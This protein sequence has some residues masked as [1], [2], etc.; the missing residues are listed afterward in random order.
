MRFLITG[1]AP[2]G[3][4]GVNPSYE[5]ARL[6]PDTLGPHEIFRTCLP[7][8]YG[9]CTAALIEKIEQYRPDCVLCLGQAAGR[10]GI[11]L[12]NTA[13]NVRASSTPDNDGVICEAEPVEVGAPESLSPNLPLKEMLA[14][15]KE[16]DIP[17]KI[18]Y[19]A[20]T[21]VCNDLFFSLLRYIA[22]ERPRLLGGFIHI[23][24]ADT[25]ATDFPPGTP[26]M[27]TVEVV[28]ALGVMIA[29]IGEM[30]KGADVSD[31][32]R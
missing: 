30:H 6:L 9:K 5:A 22:R 29:V 12:E 20:G 25:Q 15:L 21:Y 14:A 3:Q 28:R 19:S 26:T 7:V 10:D 13:V 31:G 8:A 16:V 11:S 1:F 2:F 4:S 27:P 32:L 24:A 18:S 23:P 17:A